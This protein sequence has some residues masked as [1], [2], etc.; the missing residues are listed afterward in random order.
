MNTPWSFSNSRRDPYRKGKMP[1]WALAILTVA[2]IAVILI[3]EADRSISGDPRQ[4]EKTAAR[5]LMKTAMQTI[6]AERGRLGIPIDP[7][8]DPGDTGLIGAAYNDLTTTAGS[9][10]SKSTST[11]PEFA[12]VVVDML[13]EA[14]VHPGDSVAVSFSGS[15]PALNIAVLSAVHAMKIKPVVISSIGA[16]MYGANFPNL[17]WLDMERVLFEKGLLPYRSIAAS[18]GGIADTRGGLDGTGIDAGFRAIRRNGVPFL[19]EGGGNTLRA[20][21]H[22]RMELYGRELGGRKPAAFI[23]V[24][25]PLT[26]LGNVRGIDRMP[27]GLLKKV[28]AFRDTDR[29]ILF[30]MGERKVPVL[31]LLKIRKIAAQYGIPFDPVRTQAGFFPDTPT[32]GRYSKPLAFTGL[33]LLLLVLLVLMRRTACRAGRDHLGDF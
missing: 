7:M 22:R 2:S 8:T 26:S 13:A 32:R 1:F 33:A 19:E 12:A 28:P 4:S 31:H 3:L 24:G 14:G 16:S 23:N 27:T 29:G 20:D 15:F 11:N 25:G 30:L 17:T 18:L 21:I 5:D 10:A 9:L 6:K